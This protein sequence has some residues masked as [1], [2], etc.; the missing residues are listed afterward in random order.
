MNGLLWINWGPGVY[1]G[2]VCQVPGEHKQ[3]VHPAGG[4]GLEPPDG[5]CKSG[6]GK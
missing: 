6:E 1:I 4:W 3:D 2:E 5:Q